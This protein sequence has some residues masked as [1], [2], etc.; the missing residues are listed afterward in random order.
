[1]DGSDKL[2][3]TFPP[4]QVLHSTWSPDGKT[5]AFEGRIPGEGSRLRL[6]PAD[7]G[8]A[9]MVPSNSHSDSGASW[10]PDGR[11]ILF[12]RWTI[13]PNG[14]RESAVY[15]LDVRTRETHMVPGSRD[16]DGVH[17]SPDGKYA[18][19]SDGIH[20]KLVLL[21]FAA[22]RWSELSDGMPYGWGIRWSSDS[23]YVY[24]QHWEQGEEQP[25]FRVRVSDRKVEQITSARQILRADV[26]RYT[27]TGLTP[28]NS[29]LAIL[30]NRTS[31]VYALD[32]DLR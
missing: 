20:H 23:R 26:L 16:F 13:A 28:D 32:L 1:V 30:T 25:I 18:A 9:E 10:S 3:L 19:A 21:D 11:V 29:P 15:A 31:D 2:R 22:R 14:A 12:Q 5:I 27:M 7:G 8:K 24:Y 17:W 4:M 6:V